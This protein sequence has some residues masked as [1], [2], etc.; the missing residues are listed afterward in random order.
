MARPK[1]EGLEYFPLDVDFF[2]EPK[3]LLVEEDRGIEGG[4]VAIRLFSWIYREGYFTK[5][6][7]DMSVVFAKRIGHQMTS[8]KV[9]GVINSMLNRELLSKRLYDEFQILTSR[10]IQATWYR[11]SQQA[12]RKSKIMPEYNLLDDDD[13]DKKKVLIEKEETVVNSEETVV[14]SE[15]TKPIEEETT[16]K[17]EFSTQRKEKNREE[18]KKEEKKI[19]KPIINIAPFDPLIIDLPFVSEEFRETW[20][21]FCTMRQAK[22]VGK[23][24][25][26]PLTEL[27]VKA[28]LNKLKKYPEPVALEML[29]R[30][31]IGDYQGVFDLP[32][33]EVDKIMANPAQKT[34]ET[35]IVELSSEVTLERER[36]KSNY[37]LRIRGMMGV[38]TGGPIDFPEVISVY[39]EKFGCFDQ[40]KKEEVFNP[41]EMEKPYSSDSFSVAWTKWI[42]Y[43][44][45]SKRSITKMTFEEQLKMLGSEKNEAIAIAMI[46][47][48]IGKGWYSFTAL[49]EEEKAKLPKPQRRYLN[50]KPEYSDRNAKEIAEERLERQR[51]YDYQCSKFPEQIGQPFDFHRVD[52]IYHKKSGFPDELIPQAQDQKYISPSVYV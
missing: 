47:K 29:Q 10:E 5:W 7:N 16:P 20:K 45:E 31:I 42:T 48:A 27:A 32:Q 21:D 4:Y 15:E 26:A 41:A 13:F 9:N 34:K 18:K 24:K 37:D 49:Y 38:A 8:E 50:D 23:K 36:R 25:S 12:K 17:Q 40:L 6:S 1:V 14:I 22:A 19:K 39:H 28:I 44:N 35:A 2:D 3:L 43:L 30:S 46:D 11:I 52:S 51:K 33:Y